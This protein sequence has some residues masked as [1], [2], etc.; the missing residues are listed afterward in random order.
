MSLNLKDE[1]TV[2]MISELARRLGKTKTGLV[3][4]LARERLIELDRRADADAEARD[5]AVAR[6]LT[7]EIWPH[8]KR[9]R[10][11]TKSEEENLLGYNDMVSVETGRG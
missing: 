6:W 5:E 1:E 11:L 3:R 4:E 9:S 8:T 10:P 7:D 2:A